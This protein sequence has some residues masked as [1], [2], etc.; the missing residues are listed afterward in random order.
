[1]GRTRYQVVG[2]LDDKLLCLVCHQLLDQPTPVS[3]GHYFC[4]QCVHG[5]PN[6]PRNLRSCPVCAAQLSYPHE[7]L[8]P[9]WL[10]I[11]LDTV[12]IRCPQGCD[13]EIRLRRQA[14]HVGKDCRN[15]MLVCPNHAA[16]CRVKVLRNSTEEHLERCLYRRIPCP[17]CGQEVISAELFKHQMK[18][19]CHDRAMK[20]ELAR[21]FRR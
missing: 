1:M 19:K 21:A 5:A 4:R 18:K 14:D 16:G 20:V 8:L 15:D 11:A 10:S 9:A 2:P 17:A 6:K 12:V 3:C 13:R 7:A